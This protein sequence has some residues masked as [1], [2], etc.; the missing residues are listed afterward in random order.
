MSGFSD[1]IKSLAKGALAIAV[2]ATVAVA[3]VAAQDEVD[4]SS[5]EGEITSDGSSTVGPITQA[6]AD[7][8]SEE[9]EGVGVTVDISGTGGGFERFCAGETQIQNA[10]RPISEDELAACAEN[11]VDYYVFEV[12]FDG[13]TVVVP[14][15]NTFL[16]DLT[17]DALAQ[18]WQAEAPAQTFADLNPDLPAETINLYGPGADS[19][20]YD[21]F[22]E[23][24][25]GDDGAIRED[26][27][28]SEDDNVLVT[29]VAGDANGLGYFGYAY[30]AENEDQ[31]N[32]VAINGVLPSPETI[33]DGSY[34]PLSRPLFVYVNA[35]A[36][37]DPALQQFMRYYL[38]NAPE[39]AAE[40]GFV[41]SPAEIYA[42][43]TA[44]L[45]AAIAGEAEPDGPAGAAESTPE[46]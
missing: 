34:A 20:T 46:A 6:I 11:G 7:R 29:S 18:I 44:K 3:P 26:F 38:A 31:L 12:A 27:T 39:V 15:T 30:Y 16:T 21:F 43:D 45:D 36:M 8:F 1:K 9:A 41:A 13:I 25:L 42:E 10:S 17:T 19:G 23:A 4:L 2:L 32:A 22:I 35:E 14:E 40:V 5:L 28:P 37:Q 33:A 24:V